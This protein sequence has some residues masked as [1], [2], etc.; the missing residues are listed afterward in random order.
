MMIWLRLLNIVLI[1]G[2]S[3]GLRWAIEKNQ[4]SRINH[5]NV[6]KNRSKLKKKRLKRKLFKKSFVSFLVLSKLKSK[7]KL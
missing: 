7:K 2:L 1:E 5:M 3:I 4:R 6:S